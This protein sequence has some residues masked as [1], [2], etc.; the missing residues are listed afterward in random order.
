MLRNGYLLVSCGYV[1]RLHNGD[2]LTEAFSDFLGSDELIFFLE[3]DG[4]HCLTKNE[5]ILSIDIQ[6]LI[7]YHNTSGYTR[8]RFCIF[9]K[10]INAF[11]FAMDLEDVDFCELYRINQ[12]EEIKL[13]SSIPAMYIEF[14]SESG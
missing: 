5:D 6:E 13:S 12:S 10:E 14:D 9:T 8:D 11:T 1:D 4:V 7:K 3:H 2:E